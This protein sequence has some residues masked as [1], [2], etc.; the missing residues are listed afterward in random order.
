M[1][2]YELSEEEMVN[3]PWKEDYQKW[4]YRIVKLK[5][6][7]E[8]RK[9]MYISNKVDNYEGYDFIV[10]LITKEDDKYKNRHGILVNRGWLP[11]ENK[12]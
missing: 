10:P 8:H 9:A 1:P 12:D 7:F 11:H 4:K 5:G 2:I 3:P 6:R